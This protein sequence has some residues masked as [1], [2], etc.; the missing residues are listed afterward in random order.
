M[1]YTKLFNLNDNSM[2]YE[3][4]ISK[5]D[6]NEFRE[7]DIK[8][9]YSANDSDFEIRKKID[10][11]Q[12]SLNSGKQCMFYTVYEYKF[13]DTISLAEKSYQLVILKNNNN[14]VYFIAENPSTAKK[15]IRKFLGYQI[16]QKNTVQDLLQS[17]NTYKPLLEDNFLYWIINKIYQTNTNI[18]D[19]IS[20]SSI[21]K[22][23][24]RTQILN[25]VSAEGSE[26]TNMLTTLAF[27]LESR[28]LLDINIKIDYINGEHEDVVISIHKSNETNLSIGTDVRDYNGV[29][30]ENED[31]TIRLLLLIYWEILPSIVLE[32]KEMSTNKEKESFIKIIKED[33]LKRIEDIE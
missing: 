5:I 19:V 22:V 16:S 28:H 15:C 26:V 25:R 13:I 29:Y 3:D 20:L 9:I 2:S 12:I 4:I 27:L 17:S 1:V 14:K 10:N 24:G 11:R 8:N 30:I 23:K 32:Y 18:Q 6:N 33:L 31:L 7:D 21:T